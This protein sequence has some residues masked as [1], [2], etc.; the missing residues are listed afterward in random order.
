MRVTTQAEARQ[1][2]LH[3]GLGNVCDSGGSPRR[4]GRFDIICRHTRYAIKGNSWQNVFRD[5][6]CDYQDCRAR[7][8][9][10]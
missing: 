5:N 3:I 8:Q 1:P 9:A 6:I 4:G 2:F 10:A 7:V